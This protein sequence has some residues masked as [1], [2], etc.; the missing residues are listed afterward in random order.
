MGN[1]SAI[2]FSLEIPDSVLNKMKDA[3]KELDNLEKK[4]ASVST[5]IVGN[6]SK[7]ANG[8]D[9]LI[10]K[11]KSVSDEFSNLRS[12]NIG[13]V[14]DNIKSMGNAATKTAN[15][16]VSTA[17]AINSL[18]STK[19]STS[20]QT[21]VYAWEGL[22]KNIDSL[23][24]RQKELNKVV[25]IYETQVK[26]IQS[27]KGG[28][29]SK[30]MRLS[31]ESART[32]L[33][34][35]EKLIES[36]RQKQQAIVQYQAELKKQET[37][38]NSLKNLESERTSLPNQRKDDELTALNEYYRELERVTA[39]EAKR[40]KTEREREAKK[41][42]AKTER[43]NTNALNAYERALKASENTLTQRKNKIDKLREAE[44]QLNKTQ[45]ATAERV[46]KIRS[47]ISRL[48]AENAKATKAVKN[49]DNA[50]KSL[51]NT[52]DQLKRAV[53]LVFSVS[54]IRGYITKLAQVRGEFELQNRSLQAILQNKD[55]A[56]RLFNQIT[57]LAVRSPFQL[58]ELVTYTKQLSAYRIESDKLYDT[59]KMLAD[60]SAGLGVG[61]DRLILAYGQIKAAG[62][63]R[64]TEARQLTEAGI[65]VYGELSNYYSELEG[66]IVSVNEVMDRQYKRMISFADIETIFKRLTES[67]G[68]F[69]NMQEIQ[70]DTVTGMISNLQDSIDIM[71]N[72]IGTANEGTLKT[73]IN[74]VRML[75]DNYK[76]LETAIQAVGAGLAVYAVK[77]AAAAVVNNQ[78]AKS[79]NA[80][81]LRLLAIRKAT[82]VGTGAFANLTKGIMSFVK[83]LKANPLILAASVITGAVVAINKYNKSIQEAKAKY[84]VLT[85]STSSAKANLEKL[86]QTLLNQTENLKAAKK[87]LSELSEGTEEY[88]AASDR[89]VSA[90]KERN[91]TLSKLKNEFPEVYNQYVQQ[92][93]AVDA[94]TESQSKY[95]EE[96][97][98]TLAL[99][100]LMQQ[101]EKWF[102]E[103]IIKDLEDLASAQ[104]DYENSVNN[105]SA[106]YEATKAQIAQLFSANDSL[107]SRFGDL[108]TQIVNSQE[109]EFKKLLRFRG[110]LETISVYSGVGKD[111]RNILSLSDNAYN[112][113]L[114][115]VRNI[116]REISEADKEIQKLIDNVRTLA[117]VNTDEAF[118]NLDENTK[119]LA[120]NFAQ[121][122]VSSIP[123]IENEYIQKFVNQ[124]FETRLGF[125]LDFGDEEK[126]EITGLAKR[127]NDYIEQ[128]NL[129]ID[130][131]EF[132]ET[133]S[134]YFKNIK[135]EYEENLAYIERLKVATEQLDDE[136]SNQEK[137]AALQAEN[138]E[139][140]QLLRVFGEWQEKESKT[141]S[142]GS[143]DA[144]QRLKNQISLI[145]EMNQKY[146]ELLK[147]YS[148]E[149]A[150]LKVRDAYK[151]TAA[152]LGISD[153]TA[154]MTFDASGV[155]EA[156]SKLATQ[157]SKELELALKQ[158]MDNF[159]AETEI[160]V[161]VSGREQI[162][163]ELEDMFT[164]YN[165]S[166]ELE[167]LGIPSDLAKTFGFD[168]VSLDDIKKKLEEVK[169]ELTG[170]EGEE[171]YQKYLQKIA[172]IE[173]KSLQERLKTYSEYIKKSISERAALEIAAQKEIAKIQQQ[174]NLSPEVKT[175]LITNVKEETVKQKAQLDW[176]EFQGSDIYTKMFDDL[177]YVS[178]AA[179][180][181]IKTNL[182]AIKDSVGSAF[183]PEQMKAFQSAYNKIEEQLIS[184]NPFQSM[185]DAMREVNDLQKEGKTEDYLQQQLLAYDSEATQLKSQI[186]D[187]EFIIG[188]KENKIS[189][190]NVDASFLAQNS[191]LMK[192]D[193]ET[194]RQQVALKK[195]SL[196]GV[197][198]NIGVTS[199][200]LNSYEKARKS[201]SSMSS[202]ISTIKSLGN[203]AFESIKEILVSMG[204][205]ADS[206]GMI[207]ADMGVSLVDMTLQAVQFALQL[208][209]MTVQAQLLGVAMNTALGPIGWAVLAIQ[210]IATIITSIVNAAD[211][212]KQEQIDAQLDRIEELEEK[213]E[214]L[215]DAMTNAFSSSQMDTYY[216][217]AQRNIDQ[218][219]EAYEKAI[220]VEESRKKSSE[221]DI[222]N[223]KDAIDDLEKQKKDT[224]TERISSLGGFGSEENMVS[225]AESFAEAWLDAYK[226]T[227]D[228]LDELIEKWDEYI[229]DVVAKQLMLKGM[230]KFLEPIMTQLD[231]YLDDDSVLSSEEADKLRKKIDE[232]MPLLN[233]YWKSIAESLGIQAD[234]AESGDMSGLQKGIQSVTEDTAQALES[235]LNSIR[236]YVAD[237]NTTL[238]NLYN[239]LFS[240]EE[241]V[242][243]MLTEMKMQ[244]RLLTSID[245][246]L[247]AVIKAGHPQG[248][249]G[250]RVFLD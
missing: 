32:E 37:L 105:I 20:P 80:V 228:G 2:G 88:R 83:Y 197:Q 179:L 67:G 21:S 61:M 230:E 135:S 142:G 165:L 215:V 240:V 171:L 54:Q 130:P 57:E 28:V 111:A 47:E 229:D 55:E 204:V 13:K 24:E 19:V 170:T 62:Y 102:D 158:A 97:R 180:Q 152:D 169:G 134:D 91:A 84:D 176:Q 186:A 115:E 248:G 185:R 120:K 99:N 146:K 200:D 14:S 77:A 104:K 98:K 249:E 238:K 173:T 119:E 156:F 56:D 224:Y 233:E 150:A 191:A 140:E 7:M 9:P 139:Y 72:E 31:A 148:E 116:N 128:K 232:T 213:Y 44:S 159:K 48:N 231:G 205:E 65:N 125:S 46:S 208:K 178:T 6:F 216:K 163:S 244:T 199:G 236:F 184:R 131:V 42:A 4:S 246:R 174:E 109:S 64:G 100:Y 172:D 94:L 149:E 73:G 30:D 40:E 29:V 3:Q 195:Q 187:L 241:G 167:N 193:V 234:A 223:Y 162:A 147:N 82:N 157:G 92:G 189:L 203:T 39:Q 153:I 198:T 175:T 219:I 122:F 11:L 86:T 206:V 53:A 225:A 23:I 69:Y 143:N 121:N 59:T 164:G 103:G 212:V 211:E 50:N 188:L 106:A 63:L 34:A 133:T 68:I 52:A 247:S 161:K 5:A 235:L 66:K 74:F 49:Y 38:L 132:G 222:K 237:D 95:N 112:K 87:E 108:F 12:S 78:L 210:A 201:L 207:L 155:L 27:G 18:S 124:R 15:A 117:G 79:T 75:V 58:K 114:K 45:Q 36:Y 22:Q 226:E 113:Y 89:V 16:I 93:E 154:T 81:E 182:D 177:E 17:N 126:K 192:E 183:S 243:P 245:K 90:E 145:K 26:N 101:D 136:M 137:I 166:I 8:V 151:D 96:L 35:N 1:N 70:A 168:T 218:Q 43:E 221:E 110:I 214:D 127:I 33:S 138:A 202:E 107:M 76:I 227:G 196:Q 242:N 41:S 123:S 217:K 160:D 194:L 144:L 118:I 71:L 129:S 25:S 239:N 85:N 51:I 220:A 250:I 141:T 60:V 190:E 10:Q 209:A 181:R